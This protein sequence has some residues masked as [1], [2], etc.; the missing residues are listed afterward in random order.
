[1][2]PWPGVYINLTTQGN[3]NPQK[4]P[5]K[6]ER[7]SKH[8]CKEAKSFKTVQH[9]LFLHLE[10]RKASIYVLQ[11][12]SDLSETHPCSSLDADFSFTSEL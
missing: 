12:V 7:D 8:F 9:R 2:V 5:K 10:E 4:K 1:M 11:R 3:T 6:R